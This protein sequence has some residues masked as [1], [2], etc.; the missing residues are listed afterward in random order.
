MQDKLQET[1]EYLKAKGASYADIRFVRNE[2]ESIKVTNENVDTLSRTLNHGF[3][4]RV[5][6]DGAWGFAS[7]STDRKSVV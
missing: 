4:I 5:L 6:A 3:G 2:V 7:S 1:I